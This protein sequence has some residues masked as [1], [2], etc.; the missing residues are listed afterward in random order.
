MGSWTAGRFG[1]AA[2]WW[3]SQDTAVRD[4]ALAVILAAAAFVPG[5]SSVGAQFG[6]LPLRSADVFAALLVLGQTLPLAVRTRWP[7][8]S[9]AVV[10]IC[11]AVH[12]SLGYPPTFGSLGLYLAL[13]SAGAWQ[14]RF[15]RLLAAAATAGYVVFSV[16]LHLLGSPQRLVDYAIFYLALAAFWVVGA[17]VRRHRAEEAER[18]ELKAREAASVERSRIAR[19]LH[20]VVTHHVTAMVVQADAG[21]FL[22]AW[23]DRVAQSMTAISGTGR[24]ALAELRYLLGVLEATGEPV[25]AGRTPALG[26]LRDLVEQTRLGGQPVEFIEE[27]ESLPL[28]VGAELAVYRVVQEALT[29]AIKHA[30]GRRTVVRVGHEPGLV[31]IEVTTTGETPTSAGET[32]PASPATPGGLQPAAGRGLAGLHERVRMVGGEMMAAPQPGG[33]FRVHARIPARSGS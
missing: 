11:F 26:T 2:G 20:D 7:A 33:G 8:P 1:S 19:E 23:P 17:F 16:V 31:D 24:R 9:L 15:R 29:N 6:D 28:A 27:G 18:R 4:G 25:P 14:D 30:A 5:L 12:E 10:G 22:T 21:Q 3:R 13:Y 32:E